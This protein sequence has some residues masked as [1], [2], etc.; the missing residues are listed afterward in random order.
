[1]KGLEFPVVCIIGIEQGL[2]PHDRAVRNGEL[3]AFQEERRLLYVGITRAKEELCLTQATVRDQH[4]LKRSTIA[5]PYLSEMELMVTTENEYGEQAV[6]RSAMSRNH[7]REARY[8]YE[9]AQTLPRKPLIM[10][11]AD[12]EKRLLQTAG[13]SEDDVTDDDATDD[14]ANSRLDDDGCCDSEFSASHR[15]D[16]AG[17]TAAA[18]TA[19]GDEKNASAGDD[20][21]NSVHDESQQVEQRE[22]ENAE[23]AIREETRRVVRSVVR[24]TNAVTET[25]DVA[26]TADATA[27]VSEGD[28]AADDGVDDRLK[29]GMRVRHPRYGRGVIISA[30]GRSVRATVTVLFELQGREQTF[31]AARCPLQPIESESP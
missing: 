2:V 23:D 29:P 6:T 21:R 14:D 27:G 7:V 13:G 17:N 4:G 9:A 30:S 15:S 10:S 22:E 16:S 5:S 8:R 24:V 20:C 3:A 26:E 25:S 28:V 1:A 18:F 11:A 19:A 12:L 31:V